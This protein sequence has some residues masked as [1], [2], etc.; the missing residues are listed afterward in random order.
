MLSSATTAGLSL[1]R[2]GERVALVMPPV[3]GDSLFCMVI[4]HNLIRNGRQV[5]VFGDFMYALRDWFPGV[6]IHPYPAPAAATGLLGGFDVAALK[7]AGFEDRPALG[8]WPSIAEFQRTLPRA[9]DL[10]QVQYLSPRKLML[11][12]FIDY[13]ENDLRLD[14]VV[15]VNGLQPPAGAGSH[16]MHRRRVAIHTGASTPDKRWLPAKFVK[17]ALALRSRGF[18]PHFVVPPE[19]RRD[20]AML[21]RHGLP[22]VNFPGIGELAGW[23]HQSGWFI[24][25]DSGIGHLASN[26]G[27][28]TLSLFMR[29]GTARAWRPCFGPGLTVVAGNWVPVGKL[30]ERWWKQLMTVGHALRGFDSLLAMAQH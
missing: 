27:V 19:D 13:C 24:G 5:V 3:I 6:E 28:P 30:R 18:D 21:D 20:W 26:L 15:R 16:R 8:P 23:I 22:Q 11:D 25:N 1:T 12:R 17:L 2:A 9:I 10:D 14:G 7:L 4:V 29:S